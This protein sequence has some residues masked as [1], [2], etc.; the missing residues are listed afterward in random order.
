MPLYSG[1][2]RRRVLPLLLLASCSVRAHPVA[3][4]EP[5]GAPPDTGS[6][7]DTGPLPLAVDFTVANCPLFDSTVPSCSSP[8]PFTVQFVPIATAPISQ[9]LWT[10]GDGTS[11]DTSNAPLHT[12]N[13][14]G[15]FRVTLVGFDSTGGVSAPQT[16]AGFIVVWPNGLGEPCKTDQQCTAGLSCLCSTGSQCTTGPLAG[17]CTSSCQKSDC[18]TGGV[19]ANLGTAVS[20]SVRAEPWETQVCLPACRFDADCTAGLRCRTLPAWPN[21]T[22]AVH[23]CFTDVPADLGGPCLDV[24]G[25]R[26]NDLCVTGLCADLG[27]MGLCSRDCS[28]APCPVGSD[29]AVFGDGRQLCLVPCSSSPCDKDPLLTCVAPG[30][31][32]LG[33]H[34][35]TPPLGGQGGAYCAPM[36]CTHDADCGAVGLCRKD[37]GVRHCVARPN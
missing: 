13:A 35:K 5:D 26:R 34:L 3:D 29:C 1:H 31:S 17:M 36:P 6:P 28:N 7:P 9:Y 11:E 30:L 19:C 15:P 4:A 12:Y 33:Y 23:G 24:T 8:A 21:G 18:P 10:F 14:P 37:S 2:M 20:N 25:T 27:A 22:L 32:L 16:R